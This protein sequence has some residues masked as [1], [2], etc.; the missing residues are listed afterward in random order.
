M[1]AIGDVRSV[2]AR[3]IAQVYRRLPVVFE[4]GHGV[5]LYD[6][7]GRAYLDFV[8]GIGVASLGHANARLAQAIADQADT[9][10]H[11]SNVYFHPLQGELASRLAGL[12]GLPRA[13]FTNSGTE[14]VEA[15]LKFAR[16]YW[17][18]QGATDRTGYVALEGAF[19][20]RSF[21]SLS[22]T[23]DDHYRAPF[24]PLVP[25]VQFVPPDHPSALAS[26]V[27]TRTAAVIVEPIQ[28]EGGVR[29]LGAAFVDA[30]RAACEST[31][32]L[33]I[34]DEVQS[35]LGR[36][37]HAFYSQ[38]LGLS[39]DLIAVGKALGG[40]VPVGAA[41]L[42]ERVASALAF[43]DHGST[44]GG[45]LL[46]CRAGLVFVNELEGGLIARVAALGAFLEPRLRTIAA[47]Q[48][49]VRDVRGA[50]LIWGLQLDRD[51][52]PVVEAAL[53]RGLLV[54]RTAESVIRLLPALT[55]TESELEEGLDLLEAALAEGSGEGGGR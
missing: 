48:P 18:T 22:V 23:W 52:T 1:I 55:I 12:S 14:A 41:L 27:T 47:R 42:S 40:G 2:E 31:G 4:R 38:A 45:N 34:A 28:G 13:F 54:N 39:P 19:H 43:G 11:T 26:A 8:S 35:G 30:L 44:Y 20:G 3:H 6:T 25:N 29:P 36:T 21:G 15:C 50:G 10:L 9:L 16:R 33:L 53:R 37:G 46:A 7:D 51:A 32:T 24:A 17:H 5:R 49:I